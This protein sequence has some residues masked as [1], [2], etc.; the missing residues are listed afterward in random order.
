MPQQSYLLLGPRPLLDCH[1]CNHV[2]DLRLYAL[3][4]ILLRYALEMLFIGIF[5]TSSGILNAIDNAFGGFQ[6]GRGVSASPQQE[7]GGSASR[8][9]LQA[10]IWRAPL[11]TFVI[12]MAAFE[13]TVVFDWWGW[14][15][16]A[17]S[18]WNHV[19]TFSRILRHRWRNG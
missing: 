18:A 7:A 3:P 5:T 16:D 13:V 8:P 14:S 11:V 1:Y 12:V 9:R 2:A 17:R 4:P 15:G 6:T 19:S 10:T